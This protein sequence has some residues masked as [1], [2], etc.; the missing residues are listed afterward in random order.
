MNAPQRGNSRNFVEGLTAGVFGSILG[1]G[2][3]LY[4]LGRID[5]VSFAPERL[6]DLGGWLY[7][8]YTNLG[9]SIP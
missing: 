6:P 1:A 8:T 7:W 9:S 3:I 5:L 2:A 4:I